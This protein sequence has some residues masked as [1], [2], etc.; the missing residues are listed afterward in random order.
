MKKE[1][2]ECCPKFNIEKWDAKTH[3]W[4]NKAFI[5]ESIPQLFHIPF[6]PM[7]GWKITKMW[8]MAEEAK[9]V[10][11]NKEDV[12]ILFYDPHAFKSEIY[13]TVRDDVP[14]ANNIKISGDFISKVFDG[15]YNAI[16]KFIAEM[17]KYLAQQNKKAKKYYVHYS[18]CPK[19]AQKFGHNYVVLF[20]EV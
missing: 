11:T 20:A 12:L 2:Q 18:Y 6:P 7:I 3:H 1:D 17:D 5:R 10:L 16:P 14:N 8:K 9:K 13:L 4:E 15:P 19:C